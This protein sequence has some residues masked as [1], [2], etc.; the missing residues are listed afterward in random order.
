MSDLQQQALIVTGAAA[1]LGVD[2]PNNFTYGFGADVLTEFNKAKI[3]VGREAPSDL[4]GTQRE[5]W[6]A[7]KIAENMA[8]TLNI[9]GGQAQ[10]LTREIV[11]NLENSVNALIISSETAALNEH[12]NSIASLSSGGAVDVVLNAVRG[13]Q[14]VATPVETSNIVGQSVE[15]NTTVV[16]SAPAVPAQVTQDIELAQTLVQEAVAKF[17]ASEDDPSKHLD[18]ISEVSGEWTEESLG[19]VNGL[20]VTLVDAISGIPGQGDLGDRFGNQDTY[21]REL[22]EALQGSMGDRTVAFLLQRGG[23]D[24]VISPEDRNRLFGAMNRLDDSNYLRV[25]DASVVS[26][27]QN[28]HAASSVSN[29]KLDLL[30]A[31]LGTQISNDVTPEMVINTVKQLV[32]DRINNPVGSAVGLDADARAQASLAQ[33][34]QELVVRAG[35]EENDANVELMHGLIS[36]AFNDPNSIVAGLGAAESD[37][38]ATVDIG[39]VTP[40]STASTPSTQNPTPPAQNSTQSSTPATAPAVATPALPQD[41]IDNNKL[42]QTTLNQAITGLN[43]L[44]SVSPKVEETLGI[45]DKIDSIAVTGQWSAESLGTMNTLLDSLKNAVGLSE[46]FPDS[47]YSPAL[48]QALQGKISEI[49]DEEVLSAVNFMLP[50]EDRPALFAALDDLHAANALTVSTSTPGAAAEVGPTGS[51]TTSP[52]ND[53]GS[54][55]SVSQASLVVEQMIIGAQGHLDKLPGIGGMLSSLGL[56][57]TLIKPITEADGEFGPDSQEMLAK[58]LMGLKMMAGMEN[59]DGTYNPQDAMN[60]QIEI[61]VNPAMAPIRDQLGLDSFANSKYDNT[62]SALGVSLVRF[63][64]DPSFNP[65]GMTRDE[66]AKQ[67]SDQ[68]KKMERM[69]LLFDSLNV[70]DENGKLLDEQKA[71][72]VNQNNLMLDAASGFLDQFAPGL[73]SFLQDFFTNSQFGKMLDGIL[74]QFLGINIGRLWGEKDQD[75]ANERTAGLTGRMFEKYYNDAEADL[76]EEGVASPSHA[77]IIERSTNTIEDAMSGVS[78]WAYKNAVKLMFPGADEEFLEGAIQDALSSAAE[79]ESLDQ[80]KAAFENSLESAAEAYRAESGAAFNPDLFADE[81]RHAEE[82]VQTIAA[83]NPEMGAVGA[84]DAVVTPSAENSSSVTT[85]TGEE[86]SNVENLESLPQDADDGS[87]AGQ[88]HNATGQMRDPSRPAVDVPAIEAG[89]KR[90]EMVYKPNNDDQVQGEWRYSHGRVGSIQDVLNRNAASLE[91]SLNT[92]GMKIDGVL[93]D[94]MTPYTNAVIEE[95]VIRAKIHELNESD[96]EITQEI[97]DGFKGNTTLTVEN[98][99]TVTD[100]MRHQGVSGQD[101]TLFTEAIMGNT[102]ITGLG[103]DYYSTSNT[104]PRAGDRQADTVLEQT[105]FGGQFD[106]NVAQWGPAQEAGPIPTDLSGDDP[107]RDRYLEY[108]KDRPCEV[109]LFFTKEG[110]NSAFA[111]IRDKGGDEDPSNDT[112]RELELDFY[113]TLKDIQNSDGADLNALLDNYN[114][115]N[116]TEPGVENVINFVLGIDTAKL[117]LEAPAAPAADNSAA[118]NNN[119]AIDVDLVTPDAT[120][121]R[122]RTDG[123]PEAFRDLRSLS[124]QQQNMMIDKIGISQNET[125]MNIAERDILNPLEV[126]FNDKIPGTSTG[127]IVFMELEAVGIDPEEAGFDVLLA[128]RGRNG[129][130]EYRFID[131]ETDNIRPLSSHREGNTDIAE[132]YNPHD[133]GPRRMDDFLDELSRQ[134]QVYGATDGYHGLAAIVRDESNNMTAVQGMKAIYGEAVADRYRVNYAEAYARRFNDRTRFE[135]ATAVRKFEDHLDT[136]RGTKPFGLSEEERVRLDEVA[137]SGNIGYRPGSTTINRHD[138]SGDFNS[139]SHDE[140]C[141]DYALTRKLGEVPVFGRALQGVGGIIDGV[142]AVIKHGGTDPSKVCAPRSSEIHANQHDMGVDGDTIIRHTHDGNTHEHKVE[143]NR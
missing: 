42:V 16:Q 17:N 83:E 123:Y 136:Q 89:D 133:N 29:E 24:D 111:I 126:F 106:L 142:G 60:L 25:V 138:R 132:P 113:L 47:G 67:N 119:G 2:T 129:D 32:V 13:E 88:S 91:L 135:N 122:T 58:I 63:M 43:A 96:T 57:D 114:W 90:V 59:P 97:L 72:A 86:N 93:S 118:S 104:D 137:N 55:L 6:V 85:P 109:P 53:S 87:Q 3:L 51:S 92:E 65:P 14:Q 49:T 134:P 9:S 94:R 11:D 121:A 102:Q 78:G 33:I 140:G 19:V 103:E 112:F 141:I 35:L 74:N 28:V 66:F 10:E 117:S 31:G 95:T 124:V 8:E 62:R 21:S 79:S 23:L 75:A 69:K 15:Q 52:T 130:Y 73:K 46:Q 41:V 5:E 54:D 105:H 45:S 76:K 84:A 44:M 98:L 36:D 82:H 1:A 38:T 128:K 127:P 107:L 30:A 64:N 39:G 18:N 12:T 34:S 50:E 143:A 61:M 22:G 70:L 131:Y 139:V 27:G 110:S 40:V 115:E 80:A 101:I 37:L 48:G 71:R 116:P 68:L 20:V 99:A 108:N 56:Q 100:Y 120:G 7:A 26:T 77:Q 4:D 81:V 125:I